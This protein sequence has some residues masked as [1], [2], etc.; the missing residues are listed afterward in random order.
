MSGQAQLEGLGM[1]R[2]IVRD[3]VLGGRGRMSVTSV[4]IGTKQCV[5]RLPDPWLVRTRLNQQCGRV[6]PGEAMLV[7]AFAGAGKTTMLS[8]WFT[9]DCTV[10]DRAWLTVE[11]RDNAPGRLSALLA[12]ALGAGDALGDLDGRLCSDLLVLDRVFERVAE[13]AEP[14]VLVLDDL[15]ELTSRPA[16]ATL[17][18]LLVAMPPTLIVFLAARADPPLPF[19]RMQV[20]GRL[21]QLRAAELALTPAEMA[22][23]FERYDL[24]LSETD[25]ALLHERTGGWAAAARLA[26]LALV[27]RPDREDLVDK[28][29]RTD[30]VI[31]D[32]LVHEVL[33]GV[34]A[35]MRRFL[36]RTSLAQPLTEALAR[37]LT[38]ESDAA[39][40]L[41][42]LERSGL[43]VTHSGEVP[44]PIGSTRSSASCCAR[45]SV[46]T[47]P[48]WR[49][50]CRPARRTGTSGTACSRKPNSMRT[51]PRTWVWPVNC[52]AGAS[53]GRRSPA[54]GCVRPTFR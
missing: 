35:D 21:H 44:G 50:P 6:G 48:I 19:A 4:P 2:P 31:S 38:G 34:S 53:F 41:E 16:L 51:R 45:G 36:L 10:H 30:A 47:N 15:H 13:R 23:L 37:E 28:F 32:Y 40:L 22:D 54:G 1:G 3:G 43:L 27:A 9:N 17:S 49:G 8:D 42:Q 12:R 7:A 14:T 29:V 46:T 18:H 26:A 39:A 5:P 33:D 11:T 20:E 24:H 52:R 25:V